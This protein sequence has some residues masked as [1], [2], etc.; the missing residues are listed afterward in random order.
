MDPENAETPW[1]AGLKP[2]LK[3]FQHSVYWE[4]YTSTALYDY[5]QAF[6]VGFQFDK[7]QKGMQCWKESAWALDT[8]AG[9]NKSMIQ[10]NWWY[11]PV[12]YFAQQIATHINNGWYDCW[13]FKMDFM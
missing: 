9:F 7:Y 6:Y 2:K 8:A 4:E 11:D 5:V 12:R 13:Q 10:R 3:K 1:E